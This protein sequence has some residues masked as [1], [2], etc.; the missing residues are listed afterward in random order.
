M[1]K[2]FIILDSALEDLTNIRNYISL[3]NSSYT[4][5]RFDK[6]FQEGLENIIISP[7]SRPILFKRHNVEYRKLLLQRN[8]VIYYVNSDHLVC[9]YRIFH[10]AQN[11]HKY[12]GI[13]P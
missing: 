3:N 1:S 13:K 7:R 6:E 12:L 9:I 2:D 8:I 10:Q 5:F 11:Y 4:Y